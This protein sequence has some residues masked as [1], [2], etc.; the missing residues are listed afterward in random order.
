[1]E[2]PVASTNIARKKQT[3]QMAKKQTTTENSDRQARWDAYVESYRI[4]NPAKYA[5][6]VA[7]EAEVIGLDGKTIKIPK[8][9]EFAEI[10]ESF[11]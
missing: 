4:N 7:T 2:P 10:P 6:K 9:N 5:Q 1:M 3:T 8:K 11:I